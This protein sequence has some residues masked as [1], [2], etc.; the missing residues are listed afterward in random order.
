ME[1]EEENECIDVPGVVAQNTSAEA[2][3]AFSEAGIIMRLV[4]RVSHLVNA[5]HDAGNDLQGTHR[6]TEEVERENRRAEWL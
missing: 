2:T 3:L 5:L 1:G 4:A 6:S